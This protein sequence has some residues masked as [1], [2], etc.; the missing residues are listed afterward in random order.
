[1]AGVKR[2]IVKNTIANTLLKVSQ[3]IIGFLMFPFIVKYVGVEDYGLYL[4][5]GAFVGY[6][7]LLYFRVGGAPVCPGLHSLLC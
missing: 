6:F 5:V 4:L 3:Y 2:K 1:M 7:G